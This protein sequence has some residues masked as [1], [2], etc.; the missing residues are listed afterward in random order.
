[1][2]AKENAARVAVVAGAM[3][4]HWTTIC[5]DVDRDMATCPFC[6]NC[7]YFGNGEFGEATPFFRG[8]AAKFLISHASEDGR[9]DLTKVKAAALE[10]FVIANPPGD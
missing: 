9:A 3:Q 6:D 4:H 5:S 10:Q 8:L 1:M 2:L 7:A